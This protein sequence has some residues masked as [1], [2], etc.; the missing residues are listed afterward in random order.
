MIATR[1]IA[2]HVSWLHLGEGSERIQKVLDG[3]DPQDEEAC[4]EIW[5]KHL[6]KTLTFPFDAELTE[7]NS[8]GPIRA[9]DTI[10]VIGLNGDFED[11]GI[12]VD[13]KKGRTTYQLPLA[14]L[15]VKD[16]HAPQ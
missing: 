2:S 3:V 1:E 15:K 11:Y 12:L 10:R 6:A 7:H 8:D 13:G 4:L 16:I 14:D 9:G 5:F